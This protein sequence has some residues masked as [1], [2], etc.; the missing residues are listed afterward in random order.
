[1]PSV[2]VW[3]L[4]F[5]GAQQPETPVVPMGDEA[6]SV[7]KRFFDYDAD[8]L[9]PRIVD[10]D[11]RA[12]YRLEKLVINGADGRRIP[13]RL[14]FPRVRRAPYPTVLL[15]HD[16]GSDKE[17]WWGNRQ[18]ADGRSLVRRLLATGHAVMAIDLPGH[19]ERTHRNDFVPPER[20]TI[21]DGRLHAARHMM[22]SAVVD[23]R[24]LLDYLPVREALDD[25]RV[26]VLGYGYGA[27]VSTMLMAAEPRLQGAVLGSI[28]T[29]DEPNAVFAAHHFAPR[30]GSRAL[31]ILASRDDA[32]ASAEEIR[33]FYALIPG[34]EKTLTF[35][36]RGNRL[37]QS[38]VEDVV[39]FFNN[40]M[41]KREPVESGRGGG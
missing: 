29:I 32:R 33:A 12:L 37:P 35:Y 41:P 21:A 30:M 1:M 20:L 18:V 9:E 26:G 25:T 15:I 8:D 7:L 14:A 2:L 23:H 34:G 39:R 4:L 27:L 3:L 5:S 28:P 19:G 24:R 10:E 38:H 22:I 16:L 13:V 17:S 31:L 11:L 36:D 40:L 6:F